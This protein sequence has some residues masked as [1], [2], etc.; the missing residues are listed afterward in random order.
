MA[1][2]SVRSE[3]GAVITENRWTEVEFLGNSTIEY[4]LY[5]GGDFS[6]ILEPDQYSSQQAAVAAW[7]EL[8]FPGR[9]RSADGPIPRR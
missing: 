9:D 2:A 4:V 5:P 3:L 8:F 1:S 6:T 7:F